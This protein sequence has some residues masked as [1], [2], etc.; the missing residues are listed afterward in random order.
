M[1][2]SEKSL[3]KGFSFWGIFLFFNNSSECPAKKKRLEYFI[4]SPTPM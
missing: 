3:L 1:S 4:I 2:L